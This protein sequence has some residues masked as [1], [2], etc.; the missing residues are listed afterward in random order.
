VAHAPSPPSPDARRASIARLNDAGG[1]EGGDYEK[2][3]LCK[4]ED[5]QEKP[6]KA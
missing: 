1:F 2:G 4:E 6:R 3:Q 5:R